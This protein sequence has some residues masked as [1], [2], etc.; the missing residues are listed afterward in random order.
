MPRKKIAVNVMYRA[1][2]V[3]AFPKF[4]NNCSF[5]LPLFCTLLKLSKEHA[6]AMSEAKKVAHTVWFCLGSPADSHLVSKKFDKMVYNFKHAKR[7]FIK[8]R[9]MCQSLL[10]LQNRER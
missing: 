4:I 9:C 7:M 5:A 6:M 1:Y 10:F 2:S 3:T 8:W